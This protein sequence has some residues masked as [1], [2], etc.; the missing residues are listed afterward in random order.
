MQYSV[1]MTTDVESI[2]KL[3]KL[4]FP[5]D[6]F[7]EQDENIIYW[8]VKKDKRNVGFGIAR[9]IPKDKTMFLARAGIK[10]AHVKKGLHKRLIRVREQCARRLKYEYTVTYVAK[11]NMDSFISLIKRGYEQY[12]PDWLYA[13]KRFFYL[14][15]KV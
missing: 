11:D 7:P 1:R 6:D 10:D 8:L 2:I 14:R 4:L 5:I 3:H 13:G 15:K 12:E 9:L